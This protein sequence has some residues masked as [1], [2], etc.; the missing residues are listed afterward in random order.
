MSESDS[1]TDIA[2][3]FSSL[4]VKEPVPIMDPE[5]MQQIVNT[6]VSAALHA[7]QNL[8][9]MKIKDIVAKVGRAARPHVA[10]EK[11]YVEASIDNNVQCNE[12]L[13]AIKSLPEFSGNKKDYLSFRR[14]AHVAYKMF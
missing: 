13:D 14:A 6:A 5:I 10:A 2:A 7:Q 1:V 4:I 11:V 3:L 9:D 8:F 12:G